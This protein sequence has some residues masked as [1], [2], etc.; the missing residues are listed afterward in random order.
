MK[1]QAIRHAVGHTVSGHLAVLDFWQ[2]WGESNDISGGSPHFFSAGP[3][4]P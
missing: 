1:V 3:W 2:G 4:F